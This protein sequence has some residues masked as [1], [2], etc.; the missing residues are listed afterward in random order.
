MRREFLAWFFGIK[1][2]IIK[3]QKQVK[4]WKPQE[5]IA[6]TKGIMRRSNTFLTVFLREGNVSRCRTQ[7]KINLKRNSRD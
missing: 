7:E 6:D 1:Y 2:F 5:K 3:K 4:R